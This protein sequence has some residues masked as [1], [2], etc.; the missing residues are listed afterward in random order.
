MGERLFWKR[1]DVIAETKKIEDLFKSTT[2]LSLNERKLQ[3]LIRN[4][5]TKSRPNEICVRILRLDGK[6]HDVPIQSRFF[7]SIADG[8]LHSARATIGDIKS[9][10]EEVCGV[11][12][13]C[14][15]LYR[16]DHV[17][18]FEDSQTIKEAGL[19]E[20]QTMHLVVNTDRLYW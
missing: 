8:D 19:L 5:K 10:V 14:Q 11:Q 15:M 9:K 1:S 2:S 4:L 16:D 13:I 20:N 7:Q 6:S 12:A 17:D 3:S 18:Y